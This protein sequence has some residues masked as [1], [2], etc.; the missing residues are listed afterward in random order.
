LSKNF[1]ERSLAKQKF[2]LLLQVRNSRAQQGAI[3]VSHEGC[4]RI[5][6]IVAIALKERWNAIY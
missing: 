6:F 1:D 3:L 4:R 2:D 5:Q